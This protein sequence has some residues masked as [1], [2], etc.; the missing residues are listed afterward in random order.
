[1]FDPSEIA[2]QHEGYRIDLPEQ[3]ADTNPFASKRADSSSDEE[4]VRRPIP[5][6]EIDMKCY[7]Y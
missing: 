1:M 7:G 4:D 5:I 2:A 6:I 3:P